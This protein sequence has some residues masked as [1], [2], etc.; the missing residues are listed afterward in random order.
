MADVSEFASLSYWI[1]TN[2]KNESLRPSQEKVPGLSASQFFFVQ[3]SVHEATS[4]S[5]RIT[6]HATVTTSG[7]YRGLCSSDSWKY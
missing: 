4:A 5:L 1:L 3:E 6:Q 2:L 7:K